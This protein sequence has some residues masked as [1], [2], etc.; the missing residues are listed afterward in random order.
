MSH[1]E[2]ATFLA[3]LALGPLCWALMG[4]FSVK[5]RRRMRLRAGADAVPELDLP[6]VSVLVPARDEEERIG[7]CL[8]SVLAQDYP[9]LEVIVVDD[10]SRDRTPEIIASIAESDPRVKVVRIGAGEER[11]GW[12]GKNYA[13]HV[14]GRKASGQFLVFVDADVVLRPRALRAAI[15]VCV[16]KRYDMASFL[17]R[18]E[19]Q[20]FCQGVAEPVYAGFVLGMYGSA[21]TNHDLHKKVAFANGQFMCFRRETYDAVG[22]HAAVADRCCE[23][24]ALAERAKGMGK[25]VR[26]L[27]GTELATV[28]AFRSLPAALR[29]WGRILYVIRPGSPWRILASAAFLI[30]CCLSAYAVAIA[31]LVALARGSSGAVPWL[32]AAGLHL[33]MMTLFLSLVYR[34]SKLPARYAAFFPLAAGLVL[35]VFWIALSH[36]AGG[37]VEWRGTRYTQNTSLR[38]RLNQLLT[39]FAAL[40]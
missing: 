32:A 4:F 27:V 6:R 12:T 19:E 31:A 9:D 16:A 14:A 15:A 2:A 5:S 35:A 10:R 3:Y 30:T 13:L 24:V 8:W 23:D 11:D 33:A 40:W 36:C 18:T 1:L 29:G 39:R 37:R 38:G 26:L 21:L 20:P 17:P 22:G 28:G 34:W 25:R 7:A